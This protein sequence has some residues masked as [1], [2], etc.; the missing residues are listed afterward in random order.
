VDSSAGSRGGFSGTSKSRP[1]GR[2]HHTMTV[3]PACWAPSKGCVDWLRPGMSLVFMF[4]GRRFVPPPPARRGDPSRGRY[5]PSPTEPTNELW[6]Y[7]PQLYKWQNLTDYCKVSYFIYKK[8]RPHYYYYYYYYYY[9]FKFKLNNNFNT[10][11]VGKKKNL[12]QKN[13]CRAKVQVLGLVTQR[14]SCEE[15]TTALTCWC[16]AA[17]ICTIIPR[18]ICFYWI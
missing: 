16:L 10:M 17:W 9:Y 14:L 15:T 2:V 7:T 4:G 12:I 3:F 5:R 18:M 8:S 6:S 11:N 1:D 13:M